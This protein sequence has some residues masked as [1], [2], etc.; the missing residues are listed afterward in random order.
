MKKL[1]ELSLAAFAL[2]SFLLPAWAVAEEAP[3]EDAVSPRQTETMRIGAGIAFG[4][5][6]F[7]GDIQLLA[8]LWQL[9][10]EGNAFVLL[11]PRFTQA[12]GGITNG[13]IGLGL[14]SYVPEWDVV[15]GGFLFYDSLWSGQSNQYHQGGLGVE[16]FTAAFDLRANYY[17]P[18][19][20]NNAFDSMRTT[21]VA[22]SE[23][24][25]VEQD[26]GVPRGAGNQIIREVV[27]VTER[28]IRTRTTS[29]F[30]ERFEAAMEG[31]DAE[32]GTHFNLGELPGTLSVFGGYLRYAN[33]F[34]SNVEG[35]TARLAYAPIDLLE[36]GV[37]YYEDKMFLGDRWLATARVDIPLG[38][39]NSNGGRTEME[40][41]EVRENLF[42]QVK[43]SRKVTTAESGWIED[44]TQLRVSQT[45][46][47][48]LSDQSRT[49]VLLDNVLFVDNVDGT[50]GSGAFG[51]AFTSLADATAAATGGENIYLR[52][53]GG[54]YAG[55]VSLGESVNIIGNNPFNVFA[56]AP[57]NVNST[58][59]VGG[60]A[61]LEFTTFATVNR[62]F[63]VSGID[64]VGGGPAAAMTFLVDNSSVVNLTVSGITSTRNATFEANT[65]A[66]L[67]V[68]ISNATF[69]AAPDTTFSGTIGGV[70]NYDLID[71]IFGANPP[72]TT[73][74]S[75]GPTVIFP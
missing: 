43:R 9:D 4:E 10:S 48:L 55:G 40:N 53:G 58:I 69:P 71:V 6:T 36:V 19:K 29:R 8:P 7:I 65:N 62:T 28:T 5:E 12:D 49:E 37:E 61:G 18:E 35:A 56:G 51:D 47:V 41:T 54:D 45:T 1:H 15:L 66:L 73:S 44:P 30:F 42:H 20:G 31:W 32:I 64:F 60:G 59:L 74:G 23:S 67:N 3:T 24:V 70:T 13:G 2:S 72:L 34:G 16:V 22:R 38:G 11:T 27:D 50:G 39:S 57:A 26:F 63:N 21:D 17:R 75:V 68:R 33:P 46:Q 52:P 25:R 14:R